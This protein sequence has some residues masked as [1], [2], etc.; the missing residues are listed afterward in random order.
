MLITLLQP[1]LS[2]EA[3][4]SVA[5]D[6]GTQ[7]KILRYYEAG[8]LTSIGLSRNFRRFSLGRLASLIASPMLRP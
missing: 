8:T 7:D 1:P 2:I 6:G 3:A 4:R 5:K